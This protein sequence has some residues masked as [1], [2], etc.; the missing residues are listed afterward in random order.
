MC[1]VWCSAAFI[2]RPVSRV[3][4]GAVAALALVIG[5]VWLVWPGVDDRT[6]G[7]VLIRAGA[8]L[9]AVWLALPTVRDVPRWAR[10]GLLVTVVTLIIRPRLVILAVAAAIVL[11][12]LVTRSGAPPRNSRTEGR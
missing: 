10:F 12:I 11:A 7:G 6:T 3:A 2:I 5:T 1:R 8:I 4:L 9:G